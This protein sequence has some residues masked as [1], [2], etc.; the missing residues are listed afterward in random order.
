M[1]ELHFIVFSQ[2][3]GWKRHSG[4]VVFIEQQYHF[5]IRLDGLPQLCLLDLVF[6]IVDPIITQL[7][8]AQA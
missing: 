4:L 2:Q 7:R 6:N 8:I 3:F 1:M 5:M